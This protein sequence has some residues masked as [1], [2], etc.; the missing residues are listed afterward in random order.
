MMACDLINNCMIYIYS[1]FLSYNI[2]IAINITTG[3]ENGMT[4]CTIGQMDT[5]TSMVQEIGVDMWNH[6][7]NIFVVNSIQDDVNKVAILLC[8]MREKPYELV[9]NLLAPVKPASRRY[10]D[11][12]DAMTE[13][14]QPKTF[15]TG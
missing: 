6:L 11:I 5:L 13:Y 3:D 4:Y 8:A 14:L 2:I 15:G 7:N 10:Q 1:W 9:H 12:L